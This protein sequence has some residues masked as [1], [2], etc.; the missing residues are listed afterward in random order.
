MAV[1]IVVLL[2]L[3]AL[4]AWNETRSCLWGELLESNKLARTAKVVLN[5]FELHGSLR[6]RPQHQTPSN[7]SMTHFPTMASVSIEIVERD[8]AANIT[9]TYVE[10]ASSKR[11]VT[12]RIDIIV[13]V[14]MRT[15]SARNPTDTH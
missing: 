2:V 15:T 3:D 10:S 14:L 12:S 6:P 11:D 5:R 9:S 7:Q 13:R 8:E 1:E 4:E